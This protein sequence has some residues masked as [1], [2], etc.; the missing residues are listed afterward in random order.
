MIVK[1][2]KQRVNISLDEDTVA[3]LKELAA[4]SHK[5]VSQWISDAVWSAQTK[6][7]A[8][9]NT[10]RTEFIPTIFSSDSIFDK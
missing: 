6:T 4:A 10:E 8:A 2:T 1:R 3:A 7:E 5:N 9:A